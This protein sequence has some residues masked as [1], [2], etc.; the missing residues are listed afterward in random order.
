MSDLILNEGYKNKKLY[1]EKGIGEKI[2]S[3]KNAFIDLSNNAGTLLLGHNSKIFKKSIDLYLNKKEI[4]VFAHPNLH[5]VKFSKNIK[6]VFNWFDKIIFCNTGSEA[7]T[8]SLRICRAL[9]NKKLIV[10]V[11]GSWHGSVDQFLFFPNKKL[12]PMPLSKGLRKEDKDNIIYIPYNDIKLSKQI[13]NANKKHINCI[14][15]EP[16]QGCLPLTNISNYLNFLRDFSNKNNIPLVFDEM[17]TG[18]RSP[19]FSV[20]KHLNVYSDITTLGKI[21]GGGMPIGIIGINKKISK[22]INENNKI[23]FG[24]TFSGNSLSSFI[25]NETLKYLF[26]NKQIIRKVN[27]KSIYFQ[28]KMNKFFKK[29]NL[30]ISIYRYSSILRI[31]F[32]K[33]NLNNRQQR[34][35]FE[36]NNKIKINSFKKFLLK[37][38]IFYASN[39]IIF[40]SAATSI[41]SI[42]YVIEQIKKASLL[43]FKSYKKFL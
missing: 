34:D 37:K 3:G 17:I 32:T 24:G 22:K 1:F 2:F 27:Q 8:K 5:T 13:L 14:F 19:K 15:L 38:K 36:S 23:F 29:N 18:I 4:S 41:K 35:F 6:K 20:Q 25:G 43:Y 26:K 10:N 31:I 33:Y 21:I 42:N 30:D 39:G 12:K 40:F 7:I 11:S 28:I 16:V 9:N